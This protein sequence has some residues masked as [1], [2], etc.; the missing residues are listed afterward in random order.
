MWYSMGQI[1]AS[2]TTT[3]VQS[4]SANDKFT[5]STSNAATNPAT[6]LPTTSSIVTIPLSPSRVLNI[7]NS[8]CNR[9]ALLKMFSVVALPF[10]PFVSIRFENS[11]IIRP[12]NLLRLDR[13]EKRHFEKFVENSLFHSCYC[14][15]FDLSLVQRSCYPSYAPFTPPNQFQ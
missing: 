9:V 10:L 6:G 11:L 7:Y 1:D 8:G 12:S 4:S 13:R 15:R 3:S 14:S 2:G 5:T